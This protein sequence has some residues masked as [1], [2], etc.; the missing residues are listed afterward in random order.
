MIQYGID[1]RDEPDVPG[2]AAVY[3]EL[4]HAVVASRV[5]GSDAGAIVKEIISASPVESDGH[6]PDLDP[7]VLFLDTVSM[8]IEIGEYHNLLREFMIATDISPMLMRKLLDPPLLQELGLIRST[9]PRF[10]I[11]LS[12]N[13]LYRQAN[14]NLLREETEGFSK[15]TTELFTTSSREAP[16]S[17]A[18]Q[19]TFE[20][21]KGLIGTF[22]LDVGRVLD[23]TLDVFAAVLIKQFRFF[24]K[25]LRI[26]SWWP[27][28]QIVHSAR[29]YS[30]GLPVWALPDRFHWTTSEEDEAALAVKRHDRDVAFWDRARQAHLDAFFEIGGRQVATTEDVQRSSDFENDPDVD[31]ERAWIRETKTLPSP[32]NRVAAQLLGFKLRFYASEARDADDVLPANLLYL[33]ALLI[34]V[35]FISLM[36]LWPH[37]WPLDDQMDAVREKGLKELEEKERAKRPGGG[38]NALER[39]GAL[40]DDMP[41]GPSGSS[42]RDAVKKPEAQEKAEKEAEEKPDLPE[43]EEQKVRL[44]RQL[45]LI[46]AIPESLFILGRYNWLL[47]AYPDLLPLFHR[48]IHHSV[49]KVFQDSRPTPPSTEIGQKPLPDLDQ[50]GVVKGSVKL[51]TP[52]ARRTLRWPFP[53]SG[54]ADGSQ[55]R[56]YWDEWADNVPVCQTVD[57][58]FVL[59]NTFM[60]ISG[61][62]IGRDADLVLKLCSIGKKSL[63]VDQSEHNLSRWRDLLRRLLVPALSLTEA[64]TEVVSAVWG[65]VKQYPTNVR[66]AI[67]AEWYE[68]PTSRLAPITAAFKRTKVETEGYLKRLSKKNLNEMS[69]ALAKTAVSSPG[70]VFKVA[71][72]QVEAYPNLIEVFVETAKY[73]TDMG[74]DILHWSLLRS[75]GGMQRSRTQA[76]SVLLTSQWLQR[77]AELSGQIFT[78]YS[79]MSPAP[80]L[81]Y[82][83][84]Q[85]YSGNSTDLVILQQLIS[86]M[87]GVISDTNFT[88][89]QLRAMTGGEALRREVL[90][91]LGDTREKSARSAGRL[92]KVL[93][94][95]K[96]VAQLLITIAQYRQSAVFTVPDDEAHV[97]FLSAVVDDVHSV[98][99][100]YLDLLRSNLKPDEF[101]AL[102]PDVIRLMKEFG[103]DAGLAFMIARPSLMAR[104]MNP[105]PKGDSPQGKIAQAPTDAEGDVSMDSVTQDSAEPMSLDDKMIVDTDGVTATAPVTNGLKLDSF[106]DPLQPVIDTMPELIPK[107][108]VWQRISPEFYAIFWSLQLGDLTLPQESYTAEHTR[109][110]NQASAVM[111]DRSDMSRSGMNKKDKLKRDLMDRAEAIHSENTQLLER[112]TKTKFKLTRGASSAVWFPGGMAKINSAA[113]VILEQCIL[114][115]MHISAIDAEYSFRMMKFLHESQASNFKLMALYDRFFN[116]NRLRSLIF[117]STVR[118]GEHFARFLKCVLGELSRWHG[119]KDIY[120]KEALGK[121]ERAGVK[122]RIYHGFATEFGEDGKA[123]AWLEHDQFRDLLFKWHRNLMVALKSSLSG[124]EWMHIRNT[125]TVLSNVI[126]YFPAVDFMGKQFLD[127]L[128]TISKREA[129]S[130]TAPESEEGHRV[131][132]SVLAQSVYSA[133]QKRKPKWIILQAFRPGTVSAPPP[134]K[135]PLNPPLVKNKEERLGELRSQILLGKLTKEKLLMMKQKTGGEPKDAPATTNLRPNAP[136]FNPSTRTGR[137]ATSGEVEDGEVKDGK[138]GKAKPRTSSTSLPSRP[139]LPTKPAKDSGNAALPKPPQEPKPSTRDSTPKPTAPTTTNASTGRL[140][141]PRPSSLGGGHGLP[142]RPELPSRPP[143]VPFNRGGYAPQFDRNGR[144]IPSDRVPPPRD[145]RDVRENRENRDPRDQHPRDIRDHRDSRDPRDIRAPETSRQD[146]PDIASRPDRLPEYGRPSDR[147]TSDVNP[148]EPVRLA[149]RD[150]AAR[151]EP[152]PKWNERGPASERERQAREARLSGPSGPSGPSGGGRGHDRDSRGPR[153]LHVA[154]PSQPITTAAQTNSQ[155]PGTNQDKLRLAP[156]D[157]PEII[158][159]ARAALLVNERPANERPTNDRPLSDRPVNDRVVVEPHLVNPARAALIGDKVRDPMPSPRELH[160]RDRPP[161]TESPRPPPDAPRDDHHG[162]LRHPDQPGTNRDSSGH[163]RGE[164]PSDRDSDRNSDRSRDAASNRGPPPRQPDAADHGR[165]AQQDPNYGRLNPIQSVVPDIPSGPASSAPPSGPRGRGRNQPRLSSSNGAPPPPPPPPPPPGRPD[166]RFDSPDRPPPTGPSSTTA[167]PRRGGQYDTNNTSMNPPSAPSAAAP[168]VAVGVHPDRLRHINPT[169]VSGPP[170]PGMLPDRPGMNRGPAAAPNHPPTSLPPLHTPDRPAVADVAP[171]SRHTQPNTPAATGQ[172]GPPTPTGPAAGSG[173]RQPRAHRNPFD[174]VN[175]IL[176]AGG[177]GGG[178]FPATTGN[179]GRNVTPSHP[180]GGRGGRTLLADSDAQVLTGPSPITTPVQERPDPLRRESHADRPPSRP[181]PIQT[182]GDSRDSRD[183]RPAPNGNDYEATSRGDHDRSSG[184]REHRS[185]RGDRSGRPSRRGSRERSPGRERESKESRDY[186][187]SRSDPSGPAGPV[188]G[189]NAREPDREPG[190]ARR[191]GRDSMTGSH[192]DSLPGPGSS[193]DSMGMPSRESGHRSHRDSNGP[194][195]RHD[196]PPPPPGRPGGHGRVDDYG[197]GSRGGSRQSGGGDGSFRDSRSGRTGDDRGGDDRGSARKRRSDEGAMGSDREKRPRRA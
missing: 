130:K 177:Q 195:G 120:E 14:F 134:A 10:G 196:I 190:S 38:A 88:D 150:R 151:P 128:D 17:E 76:S 15:L 32:G 86:S 147:R 58:F 62:N 83:N 139:S 20:R 126:D 115:R 156:D 84:H 179:T 197:S 91:N 4:F 159:P 194:G 129:A 16:T 169:A 124:M 34:K 45:L 9:F 52:P 59:A 122:S 56:F 95:T 53:D 167:R 11:R 55:Y 143:D 48:I 148:R 90:R 133:L 37:L 2:L 138:G 116:Q 173:N 81:L 28:S 18:V 26:S 164:R 43:P 41:S 79:N 193:R 149:E 80:V 87:G 69:R 152:P 142:N 146:R 161:R 181:E 182:V 75:L 137:K 61:V 12:T 107:P 50:T 51:V 171:G 27:R 158:N 33:S 99:I 162:R 119:S 72:A 66:Y 39:A 117:S 24:I 89:A 101:D 67:Y 154:P 178:Q 160:G 94:D 172:N 187:H 111:K 64:N 145:A 131:D 1:S 127:I 82:V 121:K 13:L 78:R 98:L 97:K 47:E 176:A 8:E 188:G 22:D 44:L 113:D 70:Q 49:E 73:Y 46:G 110:S 165:L 5:S 31:A 30:G 65:L 168:P 106:F 157:R 118:E 175:N 40:P 125:I 92:M 163:P 93:V 155:G 180:R 191:S 63:A 141:A 153:D 36:D 21:V 74:F 25:F 140:E 136:E 185:E 42:R 186:R 104:I 23:V 35:G 29:T 174:R 96:I 123:T 77:L 105:S 114:P 103:L 100:Q 112:Y 3:Q 108:E 85:V 68:G 102:V 189:S 54:D 71:L 135:P 132:L 192:R 60:N 170:T 57:D 183:S 166:G 109:L 144:P 19:A 7:A 6:S 184:R